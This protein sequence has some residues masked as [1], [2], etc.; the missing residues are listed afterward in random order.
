MRWVAEIVVAHL[1]DLIAGT[2]GRRGW[3]ALASPAPEV[4]THQRM[5]TIGCCLAYLRKDES[6]ETVASHCGTARTAEVVV[7]CI[8]ELLNNHG[9]AKAAS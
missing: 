4:A 1:P 7:A 8:A 6:I 3:T 2:G 9:L 5:A